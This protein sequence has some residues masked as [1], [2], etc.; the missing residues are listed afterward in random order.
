MN[1][2]VTAATTQLGNYYSAFQEIMNSIQMNGCGYVPITFI[3][4]NSSGPDRAQ[5][6]QIVGL[7]YKWIIYHTLCGCGY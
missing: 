6:L 7:Q 4:T 5:N 1:H 3:S 2:I